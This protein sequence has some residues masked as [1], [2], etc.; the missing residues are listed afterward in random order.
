VPIAF[1]DDGFALVP[2]MPP[3]EA[4]LVLAPRLPTDKDAAR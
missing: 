3:G 2:S 4:R 1:D